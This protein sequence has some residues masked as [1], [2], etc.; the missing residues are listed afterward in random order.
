M[1]PNPFQSPFLAGPV[2]QARMRAVGAGT[3][4][5]WSANAAGPWKAAIVYT[6]DSLGRLRQ[7]AANANAQAAYSY[8]DSGNILTETV[9]PGT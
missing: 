2:Y 3:K 4:G 8:D 6:F 7:Y 1:S 9:T 5:P